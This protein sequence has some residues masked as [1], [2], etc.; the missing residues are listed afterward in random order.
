MGLN[1]DLYTSHKILQIVMTPMASTTRETLVLG[2]DPSVAYSVVDKELH[3]NFIPKLVDKE[4]QS[5]Q[6]SNKE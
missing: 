3:I 5:Y 1:C 6:V 4:S 2:I